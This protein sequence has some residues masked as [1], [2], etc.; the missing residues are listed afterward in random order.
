[1]QSLL[2]LV[3][4]LAVVYVIFWSMRE[5]GAAKPDDKKGTRGQRGR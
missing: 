4:S 2:L 1:M 3:F 5:E